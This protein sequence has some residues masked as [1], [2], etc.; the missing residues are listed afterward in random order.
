MR[1]KL[2]AAAGA[3]ALTMASGAAAQ[4]N[5]LYIAGDVGYHQAEAELDSTGPG[6]RVNWSFSPDADWAGF[7]RIGFR[8]SPNIRL[9]LE[10]GYRPGDLE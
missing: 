6:A 3:V 10:G 8:F 5:G 7:G 2:M 1:L 9:E 4:V